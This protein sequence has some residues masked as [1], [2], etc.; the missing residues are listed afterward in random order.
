MIV[1][2]VHGLPDEETVDAMLPLMTVDG[3]DVAA[4]IL[5]AKWTIAESEEAVSG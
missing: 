1:D 2:L 5:F 4:H 3:G